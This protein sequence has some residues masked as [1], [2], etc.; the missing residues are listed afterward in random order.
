MDLLSCQFSNGPVQNRF[1]SLPI[2][3]NL[4]ATVIGA[5]IGN[6]KFY[7]FHAIPF[8]KRN[9]SATEQTSK[10]D[11]QYQIPPYNRICY[12]VSAFIMKRLHLG[13]SVTST[14]TAGLHGQGQIVGSAECR[15]DGSHFWSRDVG[16]FADKRLCRRN[17]RGSLAVLCPYR[18]RSVACEYTVGLQ[19]CARLHRTLQEKENVNALR[20]SG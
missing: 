8:L 1:N 18:C 20:F 16:I 17:Q 2:F 9:N 5:I 15:D 4:P 12:M 14:V 19:I 6:H 13:T 3:L 11:H 7:P 10:H